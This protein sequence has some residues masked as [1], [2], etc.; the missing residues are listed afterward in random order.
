MR[1]PLPG[2]VIL[3]SSD[4]PAT[5]NFHWEAV[6]EATRYA[7]YVLGSDGGVLVQ[8]EFPASTTGVNLSLPVGGYSWNTESFLFGIGSTQTV[9]TTFSIARNVQAPPPPG[10]APESGL[11]TPPYSLESFKTVVTKPLNLVLLALVV[12][13]LLAVIF[14]KPKR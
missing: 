10:H 1:T 6:P 11:D 3:V 5:V 8:R 9:E 4:V 2:Q 12:V 13:A 7:L 14:W